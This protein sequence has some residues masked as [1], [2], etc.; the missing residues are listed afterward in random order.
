MQFNH[1]AAKTD[2]PLHSATGT[3]G[4]VATPTSK[5]SEEPL[6]PVVAANS[7]LAAVLNAP[8]N[9]APPTSKSMDPVNGLSP[10]VAPPSTTPTSTAGIPAAPANSGVTIP[11]NVVPG[12]MNSGPGPTMN[13]AGGPVPHISTNGTSSSVPASPAIPVP[14]HLATPS[15]MLQMTAPP[16]HQQG[17]PP[18][19]QGPPSHQQG[20]PPHHQGPPPHHQGPPPH[21]QGPPPH[22]QGPPPHQQGP[23]PHQQG[24]PPHQQGPPSHQ[25][26]P[27]THQHGPPHQQ[28][29]PPHQQGPLPHQ[30]GPLSHQQGPPQDMKDLQVYYYCLMHILFFF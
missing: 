4:N 20:L 21:H 13:I 23:P 10:L 26:G 28:G 11:A 25:Q 30:Q 17:P 14:T 18:H 6:P 9:S 7:E 3:V 24:P 1:T 16:P 19:Q 22:Q 15:Q 12:Q 27:P 2:S 29:P 8:D 5:P